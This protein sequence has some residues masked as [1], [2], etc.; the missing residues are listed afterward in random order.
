MVNFLV[1]WTFFILF[2]LNSK[3]D[4]IINLGPQEY[5]QNVM[6]KKKY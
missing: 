5:F 6:L 3:Y 1:Q 4:M 2:H